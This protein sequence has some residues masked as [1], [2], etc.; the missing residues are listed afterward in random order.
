MKLKADEKRWIR[1]LKENGGSARGAT[2]GKGRPHDQRTLA[3]LIKKNQIL[4]VHKGRP[5]YNNDF[6]IIGEEDEYKLALFEWEGI[7]I[8]A[9][10]FGVPV[11]PFTDE[12]YSTYEFASDAMENGFHT[13]LERYDREDPR[14][15]W[16]A[17][18]YGRATLE[19]L[20]AEH[21][22]D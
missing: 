15:D 14:F 17:W 4:P 22:Q 19:M 1:I 11:K 21:G 12:D 8:G 5:E 3:S 10:D 9:V 6:S 18:S 20:K 13:A 7:V 16:C 2:L